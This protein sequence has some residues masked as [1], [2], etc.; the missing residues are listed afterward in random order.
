MAARRLSRDLMATALV[1]T[2]CLACSNGPS[3]EPVANAGQ[4]VLDGVPADDVKFAAVGALVVDA[5]WGYEPLCSGTLVG[6]R[7]VVTAKHCTK[8]ITNALANGEQAYFAFGFDVLM[9]DQVIPI[10]SFTAAPAS[11]TGAGLLG[12]G[13]RDVAV[14]Y[15]AEA[16]EGIVP[17]KLGHF[18][19]C[20]LG[21]KFEIAGYGYSDAW[22]TYGQRFAGPAT[23]RAVAGPWYPLL[24]GGDKEAFLE[25]YWTDA[26]T[27]PSDAEAQD[28]WKTYRLEPGYELLA[29]GLEGEALGCNGDS[30]GPILRGT[31]AED[32]TVYG[33][34][35]AVESSYT[36]ICDHGAAYLVFNRPMLNFVK[37]AVALAPRD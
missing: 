7:S 2:A 17:A 12:N 26:V 30:G 15:L 32:V 31:S 10:T 22:G 33:V 27:D 5:P 28:W 4:T 20:M 8:H 35:F 25:W 9:P 1:L 36:N 21:K 14:A 34:S 23:A 16:P 13:G 3:N 29:G 37:A 6:P 11:A 24:F 19:P 18:M